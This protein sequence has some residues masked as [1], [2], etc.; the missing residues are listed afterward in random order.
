MRL[1]QVSK[2]PAGTQIDAVTSQKAT[3]KKRR[4]EV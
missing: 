1:L 2:G 3:G 4:L